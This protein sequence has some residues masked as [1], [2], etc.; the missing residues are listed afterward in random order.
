[1]VV[2]LFSS[3][4]WDNA[5]AVARA[6]AGIAL[7]AERQSRAV[8]ELPGAE[9]MTQLRPALERVLTDPDFKRNAAP[10]AASIEALPPVDEAPAALAELHA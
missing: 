2:P 4:Q 3:D 7:D 10:V 5:A 1:V 6:G 8:L 9:T